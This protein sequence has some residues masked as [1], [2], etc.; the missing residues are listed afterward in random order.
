METRPLICPRCGGEKKSKV[1]IYCQS[2]GVTI[3]AKKVYNKNNQV[4]PFR[5]TKYTGS[6]KKPITLAEIWK[7]K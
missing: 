5:H 4:W 3:H 2:C 7:E 1:G 6:S